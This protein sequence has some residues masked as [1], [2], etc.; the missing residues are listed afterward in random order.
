MEQGTITSIEWRHDENIVQSGYLLTYPDGNTKTELTGELVHYPLQQELQ[1]DEHIELN[2]LEISELKEQRMIL[3]K[4]L[5][6]ADFDY[7]IVGVKETIHHIDCI[8]KKRG[9]CTHGNIQTK[10]VYN[11]CRYQAIPTEVHK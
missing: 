7:E 2:A 4:A 10:C 11:H 3:E 8:F 1:D 5:Q 6:H 9:L